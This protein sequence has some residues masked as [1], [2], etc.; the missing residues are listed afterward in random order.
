M[1]YLQTLQLTKLVYDLI[2]PLNN[3]VYI[4]L[5]WKDKTLLRILLRLRLK[6]LG[7]K[8]YKVKLFLNHNYH[9]SSGNCKRDLNY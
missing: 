8:E 6:E 2:I 7:D 9:Q 1:C 3:L 4:L 5:N